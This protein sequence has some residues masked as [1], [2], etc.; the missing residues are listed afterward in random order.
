ME[1]KSYG[2]TA[3][4]NTVGNVDYTYRPLLDVEVGSDTKSRSFKALVD[5]GTDITVM[6]QSIA[7]LLEISPKGRRRGQLSGVGS[8]KDGFI[9]PVSLKIDK[10]P[11]DTFNFRVLFVENLSKNF[12]IILGQHDFFLNFTVTFKKA[13][14]LFYL[15][16]LQ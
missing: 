7:E 5:S 15:E 9:A 12:E 6:D 10:F 4:V 3:Q 16:R 14:S 1:P 2:Y 13:E 8:A 11:D